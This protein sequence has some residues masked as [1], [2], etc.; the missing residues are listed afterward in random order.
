MD[1]QKK[2][3]KFEL[4]DLIWILAL[5][6][7]ATFLI[8]PATHAIFMANTKS[9]PY[10][11][12]FIKVSILATMGELLAL[13][14]VTNE[15]KKTSGM[16]YRGIIWG[17]IGMTFVIVF[18][19]FFGGV[20]G[21]IAKHLLPGTSDSKLLT[22][23]LT[24]AFMNLT[25]AP[26]FMAFHRVTDTFIDMGEGKLSKIFAVKLVDVVGK[27]D[28]KGFISFVVCKTI[29]FFW[30]PAHTITFMLP[31]EYRVLM[32]AFLSIALG[33]ILAFAKKSKKTA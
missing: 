8:L 9:H 23:F 7:I 12:G 25:F 29:P 4:G 11:M 6:C 32:A 2:G 28:W 10:I 3:F 15:W 27:I 17:F 26:T 16:L 33:G 24:S 19:I 20:T 1:K 13:R 14:I 5:G 18:D 31:T 22:A 21:S 30:I